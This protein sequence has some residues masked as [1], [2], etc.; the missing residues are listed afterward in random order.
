MLSTK[1]AI[2]EGIISTAAVSD[3]PLTCETANC[4]WPIFPSLAV[5]GACTES[6]FSTSCDSQN[7]CSYSMPSGT[8]I[9]GQPGAPFDY[10]FIVEPSNQSSTFPAD[11]FKATISV[12]DIMSAAKSSQD[13]MVQAYQCGLWFCLRSYNATVI[14]GVVHRSVTAE[15]AKSKFVHETST[16]TDEFVF[17]D[18]PPEMNV[19]TRYSVPM[20]S[21]ETLRAL[22]DKL[23]LGN[24][25]QAAG[26]VRYDTDWIQA[27]DAAT[28]SDLSGWIARF[29]RSL[30]RNIQL[31]GTVQPGRNSMYNGTAYIMAPHVVVNWYWVIYPISLM[32]LAFVYLIKTVYITARDQV[33]AWKTDS[34]PVSYFVYYSSTRFSLPQEGIAHFGDFDPASSSSRYAQNALEC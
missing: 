33:C 7:R 25:S 1:A 34:L 19:R 17:V 5:C 29:A 16:H 12:F 9:Y 11:N 27:M 14:N 30:T 10:G 3:I 24:A 22:I 6:L 32:I 23:T 26:A 21:I 20:D 15:W 28:Q 4:S 2:Y 31:T 13:S 8:S 18:I